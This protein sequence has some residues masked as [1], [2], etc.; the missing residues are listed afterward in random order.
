MSRLLHIDAAAATT[1]SVSRAVAA[2]FRNHWR[3]EVT[4]RDL[5]RT[6]VPHIDE[7]TIAAR[8]SDR[9]GHTAAQATAQSVQDELI[10]EM[11]AADAF[12]FAVPMYNWGPPS[13]F[14]AWLDQVLVG[15]RT[16]AQDPKSGPL[17][18]RPATLIASR[19]GAYGPGAPKEG[20]DFAE[21]Y[22]RMLLVE[23]FG[24]DLT[25][26]TPE[27]TLADTNPAMAEFRDLAAASLAAA[28][29]QATLSARRPALQTT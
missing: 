5:G 19:G 29:E 11:L 17:A 13:T 10:E 23:V 24:L 8:Y 16:V 3:G 27:F 4:Y 9:A 12:L 14:K 18:G 15:G 25:V 21:P 22:L 2:T 6:P 20:W 1:G 28:H 26:I 7:H